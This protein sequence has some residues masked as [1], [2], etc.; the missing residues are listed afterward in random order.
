MTLYTVYDNRTDLP[1]VTAETAE[2]CA[3]AMGVKLDT[4]HHA[5]NQTR[6]KRWT[7]LKHEPTALDGDYNSLP[8]MLRLSQVAQ[9]LDISKYRAYKFCKERGISI[10]MAGPKKIQMISRDE[11]LTK[12]RRENESN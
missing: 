1:I 3:K 9:I 8:S 11:F 5:I 4:F 10:I 7:V 2:R 6:G 12:V